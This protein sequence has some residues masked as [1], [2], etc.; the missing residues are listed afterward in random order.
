MIHD[1]LRR[2]VVT[3][4]IAGGC[5]TC[6]MV[7]DALRLVVGGQRQNES[8]DSFQVALQNLPGADL[9]HPDPFRRHKLEN[10]FQVLTHPL[11]ALGIVLDPHD[12]LSS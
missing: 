1:C 10:A 5:S 8:H 3:A 12:L 4:F 11:K 9:M 7:P 2:T 6:I